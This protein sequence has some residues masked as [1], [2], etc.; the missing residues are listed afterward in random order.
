M[1]NVASGMVFNDKVWRPPPDGVAACY[2]INS[3]NADHPKELSKVIGSQNNV[4]VTEPS[5]VDLIV[6]ARDNIATHPVHLHGHSFWIMY[7]HLEGGL[8]MTV[9]SMPHDMIRMDIPRHMKLCYSTSSTQIRP[10]A[11]HTRPSSN[12][13]IVSP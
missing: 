1:P 6:N 4:L 3:S 7:Q 2:R 12:A 9:T 13:F 5:V 10:G 11:E 8:L